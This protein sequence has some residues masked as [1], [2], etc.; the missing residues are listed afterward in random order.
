MFFSSFANLHLLRPHSFRINGDLRFPN[1]DALLSESLK[2]PALNEFLGASK[3]LLCEHRDLRSRL[4]RNSKEIVSDIGPGSGSGHGTIYGA[5]SGSGSGKVKSGYKYDNEK[6]S[7]FGFGYSEPE[8]KYS[9]ARRKPMCISCKKDTEP[10]NQANMCGHC[11]YLQSGNIVSEDKGSCFGTG[12]EGL[13]YL[14][15]TLLFN[16]FLFG[17]GSVGRGKDSLEKRIYSVKN[18]LKTEGRICF[19]YKYFWD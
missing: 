18:T 8:S 15:G 9:G 6:V 17:I 10:G 3:K 1:L 16:S 5:R 11:G 14:W 7:G 12:F 4:S 19:F 13:E 2:Y